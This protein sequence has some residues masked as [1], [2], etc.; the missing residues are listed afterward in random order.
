M[1]PSATE[2]PI[3]SDATPLILATGFM[4]TVM[5]VRLLSHDD[6]VD[7]LTYQVKVPV[8]DVDGVG[9]AV[10][11]VP[12][13]ALVNQCNMLPGEALAVSASAGALWQYSKGG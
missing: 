1:D 7:W 5:G 6:A 4:I 11:A 12:P 2:Q 9:G 3:G 8:F 13:V 10:S